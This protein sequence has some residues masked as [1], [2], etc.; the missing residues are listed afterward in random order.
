MAKILEAGNRWL[1]A[2]HGPS[3]ENTRHRL[4]RG[5]GVCYSKHRRRQ[6]D[7]RNSELLFSFDFFCQ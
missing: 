1:I 7:L 2:S 5:E 4:Y 6:P 3:P